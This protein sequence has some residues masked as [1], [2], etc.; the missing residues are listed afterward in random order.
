VV[1]AFVQER[2]RRWWE[3]RHPATDS[4]T[5][6]QSNIY[7]V[8]TRAGVAF[9]ITLV[10][11]L[12]ASI[13][14]QLNLGYVLTFLLAGSG[15]TSLHLTHA[16]L[17]GLTLHLRQPAPGFAGE[18]TLLEVVCT[19]PARTRYGIGLRFEGN[20][21]RQAWID[22][23]AGGQASAQLSFVPP[24]RGLHGVPPLR[25]ETRFPFGLFRAWTIWR[26]AARVLAW[27]APEKPAA[28]LPMARSVSGESPHRRPAEGGELEGVRTYR[29]GDP[30]RRVVWKKAAKTG[31]LVSRDTSVSTQQELWLEYQATHVPG[32]EQRLSRLAAWIVAAE[33]AG[34]PHGLRLPGVEL[35]P[36]HGDAHRKRALEALALWS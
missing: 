32:V 31:Q 14:Y 3:A 7:I 28:P 29:R 35:A 8:P 5:L 26:P 2:W 27:P 13:N 21:A 33:R 23:P 16:T 6:T 11:M 30:L 12:L 4:W 19:S 24:R 36:A 17:R 15:F 18:P 20:R 34:V 22:V 25:A 10:T 9:A 1:V